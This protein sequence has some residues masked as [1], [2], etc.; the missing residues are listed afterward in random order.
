LWLLRVIAKVYAPSGCVI[1]NDA[2]NA[3]LLNDVVILHRVVD[4]RDIM[5]QLKKQRPDLESE[6]TRRDFAVDIVALKVLIVLYGKG[7][8]GGGITKVHR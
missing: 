5:E 4:D 2:I 8:F 1:E 6:S 7:I 3:H